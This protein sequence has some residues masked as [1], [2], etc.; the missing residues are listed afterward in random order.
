M[1][2][3]RWGGDSLVKGYIV[4]IGKGHRFVEV[5]HLQDV[6]KAYGQDVTLFDYVLT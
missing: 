1:N 6:L 2:T 4:E 3:K 5:G